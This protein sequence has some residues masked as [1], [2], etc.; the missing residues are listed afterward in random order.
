MSMQF[1]YEH[2]K[3][4]GLFVTSTKTARVKAA[5]NYTLGYQF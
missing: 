3:E 4:L 2:K 5:V 1:N